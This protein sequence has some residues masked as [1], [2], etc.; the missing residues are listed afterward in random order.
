[1]CYKDDILVFSSNFTEHLQ[2]LEQ[3][4]DK[5]RKAKLTLKSKKCHFAVDR[6]VYLSHVI[7]RYGV[8][9]DSSKTEVVSTFPTPKT[10]RDVHRFL[11]LCNYYRRFVQNFSKIATPLKQLLQKDAKFVWSQKCENAFQQLKKTLVTA[12]MLQYPDI[13][14][15]FILSTDASGTAIG[16]ILR[17]KR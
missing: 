5:L 13:N 7:T 1:M 3:V 15:P 16:Y 8:Q 12:P 14:S 11:G 10:R 6:V 2:N 9:V 17:Q 4:F